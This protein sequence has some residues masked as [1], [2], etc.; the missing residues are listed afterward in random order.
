MG[1]MTKLDSIPFDDGPG[2]YVL[3]GRRLK[4]AKAPTVAAALD[5][6]QR[7][8][9][10]F[11]EPGRWGHPLAVVVYE[12]ENMLWIQ[13]DKVFEDRVRG[14]IEELDRPPNP[15]MPAN[16]IRIQR[17]NLEPK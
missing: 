14:I 16:E 4:T 7:K 6:M 8:G 2:Q 3:F 12:P 17:G 9:F 15:A 13:V 5:E 11:S 1:M 10:Q